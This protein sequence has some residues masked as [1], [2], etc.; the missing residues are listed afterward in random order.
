MEK[1]SIKNP[2]ENRNYGFDL[3][4]GC[5]IIYMIFCHIMQWA[6][7]AD[8]DIYSILQRFLFF[9]MAWFFYKSGIYLKIFK[10]LFNLI[11]NY[12]NKSSIRC[13]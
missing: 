12:E 13:Y 4:S 10:V 5:L 8:C 11:R 2:I 3:M 9:F 7:L 1:S 6:K